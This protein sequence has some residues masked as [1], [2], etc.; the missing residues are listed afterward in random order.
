[1]TNYKTTL[2]ELEKLKKDIKVKIDK[3]KLF[4]AIN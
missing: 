1:M 2:E 4:E 3:Q